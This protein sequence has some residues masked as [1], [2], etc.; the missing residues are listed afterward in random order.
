MGDKVL[1][2]V[3]LGCMGMSDV[4]GPADRHESIRT[5]HA[6]LDAG[7]TLIDTGDFYG[8]GHNELLLR[9]ALAG[10][11]RDEVFIAVKFGAMRTPL[12]AF[13]GTD[14]RPAAVK[15]FL[16]YTLQRLG[17]EYVDLYQ[18]A[19]VDPNVPIEETV[20]AIKDMIEAGFVRHVGLSEAG[21]DTLRRAHQVHPIAWLQVE[22]SLMSRSIEAEILPTARELGVPISAYGVLSRGLLSGRWSSARGLNDPRTRNFPRFSGNNLESNLALVEAVRRVAEREG[23]TVAQAA[24]AWV[25]SRG[26]DVIPLIGARTRAQLRDALETLDRPV[27][28]EALAEIESSI[29]PDAVAGDRYNTHGMLALDSERTGRS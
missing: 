21:A 16:S 19:R 25:L 17:M 12:R 27:S 9:E 2:A 24:L 4:Y 29:P 8:S 22:Y 23:V 11:K 18:P 3:G 14:C 26:D 20:G 5:I 1:P 7:I 6:A 13:A 10:R 15:N 28:A